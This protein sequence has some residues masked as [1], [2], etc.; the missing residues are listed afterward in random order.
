MPL[1]GKGSLE[2][3]GPDTKI[4]FGAKSNLSNLTLVVELALVA[5]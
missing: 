3:H 1:I 2:L 5:P 4:L